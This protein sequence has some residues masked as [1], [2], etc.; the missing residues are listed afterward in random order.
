MLA[1]VFRLCIPLLVIFTYVT[2]RPAHTDLSFPSWTRLCV[3]RS[4]WWGWSFPG[5]PRHRCR[6]FPKSPGRVSPWRRLPT[7]PP[8]PRRSCSSSVAPPPDTGCR[9][10][11]HSWTSGC[12]PSG[13]DSWA[14]TGSWGS[15]SGRRCCCWCWRSRWRCCPGRAGG[16]PAGWRRP[17]GSRRWRHRW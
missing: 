10:G 1:A 13:C 16:T 2:R 14:D 7:P 9:A 8:S 12:P 3:V 5:L 17:C 4:A 11:S 6:N 15:T